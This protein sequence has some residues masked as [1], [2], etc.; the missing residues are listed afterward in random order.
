MVREAN[1]T[2][3]NSG[4]EG[5]TTLAFETALWVIGNKIPRH[6]DP[7]QYKNVVIR[8]DWNAEQ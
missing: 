2:V 6:I 1:C 7:S 8:G 5:G 3:N 4:R